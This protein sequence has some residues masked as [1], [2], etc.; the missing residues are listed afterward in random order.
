MK[1]TAYKAPA[2]LKQGDK[3]C[4]VAPAGALADTAVIDRAVRL[5]QSRGF[6]TQVAPQA[7]RQW[8]SLAGSDHERLQA[9]QAALDDPECRMIWALRGGYGSIRIIDRLDWTGFRNNPKWIA[10]FSDIT[11]FHVWL[12]RLGYQS[13]HSWMPVNLDEDQPERVRKHLFDLL[14]G[15]PVPVD[16][17]HDSMNL[18]PQETQGILTGGNLAT[19]VSMCETG[20]DFRGKMLFL[21][22]VGEHLYAVDRLLHSLEHAGGL[23]DLA[24]LLVGRFTDIRHDDPPF[25]LTVKQIIGE[26]TATKDYPV[27]FGFP[28]GHIPENEP[29]IL[30]AEYGISRHK[31]GWRFQKA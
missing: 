14:S 15:K 25:P 22:D 11:V 5:L 23:N 13:V 7:Y 30:G 26:L 10:G 24:G 4:L 21:E 17:P 8:G 28:A 27:F 12:H 19:L 31:G 6:R 20:F 16:F 18:R 1:P 3:V 9:M 2:P 29:M